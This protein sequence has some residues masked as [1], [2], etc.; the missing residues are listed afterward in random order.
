MKVNIEGSPEELREVLGGESRKKEW[1][2]ECRREE[3]P[4]VQLPPVAP[5]Q[6][7]QP[8]MRWT[9]PVHR[10]VMRQIAD[11][12]P[13]LGG[14][15]IG[16]AEEMRATHFIFDETGTGSAVEWIFGHVRIN[17]ILK[18]YTAR[19]MDMKG[20]LHSHPPGSTQLSGQDLR[21]FRKPFL[22]PKNDVTEIWAPLVVNGVIYPYILYP[23][24]EPVLAQLV[25]I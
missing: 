14:V 4:L 22:N 1:R 3:P 12:P 13:E 6:P 17:E 7:R 5:R 21:D 24:G 18:E 19:G 2:P 25:L 11:K 9:Q 10:D 23:E 20:F 16:P 15:L 8:L